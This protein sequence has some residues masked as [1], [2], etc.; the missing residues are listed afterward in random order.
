M[1][2]SEEQ[3][4]FVLSAV[5]PIERK[6]IESMSRLTPPSGEEDLVEGMI[7][8]LEDGLDRIESEPA[9][10]LKPVEITPASIEIEKYGLPEC[11]V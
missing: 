1:T 8:G 5:L 3:E 9:I 7:A 4:E 10:A 6:M 2:K 11:R